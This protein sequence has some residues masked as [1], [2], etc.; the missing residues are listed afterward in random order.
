MFYFRCSYLFVSLKTLKIKL[1]HS[2]VCFFFSF[3]K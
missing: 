1:S 3:L 2:V